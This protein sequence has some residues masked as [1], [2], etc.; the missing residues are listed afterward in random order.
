MKKIQGKEENDS[1][2]SN[3]EQDQEENEDDENDQNLSCEEDE[4]KI[5]KDNLLID[6]EDE[7]VNKKDSQNNKKTGVWAM[8]FMDTS[9]DLQNKL[10]NVLQEVDSEE[11]DLEDDS[12]E[13]INNRNKKFKKKENLKENKNENKIIHEDNKVN[14]NFR[15]KNHID[16]EKKEE[17]NFNGKSKNKIT[18]EVLKELNDDAEVVMKNDKKNGLTD[19]E[20]KKII[21][22]D[23]INQDEELFNKFLIANETNKK[24]FLEK[25][26]EKEDQVNL[27]SGWN[28]W[29]GES[30]DIQAK[31][32]LR[33]KRFQQI[34]NKKNLNSSENKTDSNPYVKINNQF[35][36]K[37]KIF[38]FNL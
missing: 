6:F 27:L 11:F 38:F 5:K 30:K 19:E 29:A 34:Q 28:S 21:E 14:K 25:P 3:E 35:D 13:E 16:E 8:K 9:N 7:K 33:K 31:E 20:L 23:E 4:N 2:L 17:N 1:E 37:V 22:I 32:F 15:R 36:K 18:N 24:E 12:D 26:K 10:K